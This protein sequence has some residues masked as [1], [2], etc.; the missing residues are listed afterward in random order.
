[1]MPAAE[2]AL[3]SDLKACRMH[4]A[5]IIRNS[6]TG[7][8]NISIASQDEPRGVGGIFYDYLDSG[9]VEGDRL[10]P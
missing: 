5:A 3:F 1:M 10:Y 8:T 9:D 6:K 2:E 7:V 4:D